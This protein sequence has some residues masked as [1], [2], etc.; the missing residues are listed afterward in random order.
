[1]NFLPVA[2]PCLGILIS[3]VIDRVPCWDQIKNAMFLLFD[4]FLEFEILEN[5]H[6]HKQTKILKIILGGPQTGCFQ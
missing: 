4:D 5:T 3:E 6:T 1:M 2:L